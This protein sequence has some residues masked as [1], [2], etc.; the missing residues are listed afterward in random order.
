MSNTKRLLTNDLVV[1][2]LVVL[3]ASS[4]SSSVSIFHAMDWP[5]Y[6]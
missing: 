4:G 3:G 2:I 5:K 6:G 1:H